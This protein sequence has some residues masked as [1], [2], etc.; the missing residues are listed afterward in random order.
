MFGHTHKKFHPFYAEGVF[1]TQS[2][3]FCTFCCGC[4]VNWRLSWRGWCW[5]DSLTLVTAT[6]R[7]HIALHTLNTLWK[8]N[9]TQACVC[10]E[11]KLQIAVLQWAASLDFYLNSQKIHKIRKRNYLYQFT[12]LQIYLEACR[13]SKKPIYCSTESILP[14]SFL[15]FTTFQF[16]TNYSKLNETKMLLQ[17]RYTFTKTDNTT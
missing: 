10:I 12:T 8:K 16:Q 1:P 9:K 7:L 13:L 15:I 11:N 17:N 4:I 2:H 5:N 6:V 14:N 3:I